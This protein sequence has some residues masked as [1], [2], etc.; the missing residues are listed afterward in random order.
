MPRVEELRKWP[1]LS[2]G[3]HRR[4]R[5]SSARR[6]PVSQDDAQDR[7]HRAN[8]PWHHRSP[9]PDRH[10][11]DLRRD[12]DRRWSW[13]LSDSSKSRRVSALGYLKYQRL[14][15]AIFV[16]ILVQLQPQLPGVHPNGAIFQRTVIGRLVEQRVANVLLG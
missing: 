13:R 12:L 11:N 14:V 4:A 8:G 9:R 7:Q 16:E 1:R 2:S 10:R 5:Q 6:C 3:G 15:A